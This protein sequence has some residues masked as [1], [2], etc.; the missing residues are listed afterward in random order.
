MLS[1]LAYS[2]VDKRTSS[3]PHTGYHV[4]LVEGK[5][6]VQLNGAYVGDYGPVGTRLDDSQWHHLAV[7]VNSEAMTL[8]IYVD[9]AHPAGS[10]TINIDLDTFVTGLGN[11][12]T[13]HIGG[14]SVRSDFC[15]NGWL[16]E[17]KFYERALSIDE[18]QTLYN[19][20]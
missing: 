3:W 7:V 4:V 17:F 1:G 15:F 5:I 8:D 2:I 10:T 19:A 14:H 6:R 18:V 9:G 16:D 13:L 11:S 12:N 20:Q